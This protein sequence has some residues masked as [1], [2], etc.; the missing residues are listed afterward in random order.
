MTQCSCAIRTVASASGIGARRRPTAG[1]RGGAREAARRAPANDLP[2]PAGGD[3]AITR[4]RGRWDGELVQVRRD[5]AR[6]VVASRWSQQRDDRGQP[7]AILQTNTD[8]TARK[9]ADEEL[10]KSEHRYRNMFELA[11]DAIVEEDFSGVMAV[12]RRDRARRDRR[13]ALPRGAPRGRRADLRSHPGHRRQPG[14]SEAVRRR[15]A[16]RSS[17]RDVSGVTT[18]EPGR[19]GSVQLRAIAEGKRS[20]ET[21]VS[22]RPSRK[23]KVSTIVTLVLPPRPSGYEACSV[24]RRPHRAQRAAGG[25]A[26]GAVDAR[27]RDA[28]HDAGASHG[29]DRARGEP[30]A[31]RDRSTMAKP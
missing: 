20:V 11:G 25:V 13:P 30:A 15:G 27:P 16:R 23:E 9:H 24:R 1:P 4:E 19:H 18:P 10:R 8:I 12:S 3:R 31:R 22:S 6:I 29:V 26:P 17:S 7:A 5:G 21:E 28:R 14:G 2:R